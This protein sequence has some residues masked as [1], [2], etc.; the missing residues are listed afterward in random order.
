[1]LGDLGLA[2]KFGSPNREMSGNVVTRCYRSPEI[3]YGSKFY[4]EG[5]D[6]W[7]I[8][9][10]FAEIFMKDNKAILFPGISELD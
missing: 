4:G 10:T 6:M 1:M 9:C 8:G 5:V 2:R 3:L 7:S